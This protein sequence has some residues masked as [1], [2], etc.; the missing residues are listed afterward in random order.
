M[1]HHN[2]NTEHSAAYEE[3]LRQ[4]EE[5]R[6]QLH[7]T[8]LRMCE[9]EIEKVEVTRKY[10]YFER[11][12]DYWEDQARQIDG[13]LHTV[14][15]SKF[16]KMREKLLSPIARFRGGNDAPVVEEEP[17]R[18]FPTPDTLSELPA[19]DAWEQALMER[20]RIAVQAHVFYPD[21]IKDITAL[22]ANL[23][24]P[25]DLYITTTEKHKAVYIEEYL[26]K[27]NTAANYTVEI[28]ENRGRDVIPFLTQLQPVVSKYDYFCH[29]HTKRSLLYDIGNRWRRYLYENL[30][31]NTQ[32]I[33]QIFREFEGTP[34]V[35]LIFPEFPEYIKPYVNWAGNKSYAED[36]MVKMGFDPALL[37]DEI[38][39]PA[40]TMFWARTA[41][42]SNFFKLDLT[43]LNVP[44][45]IGQT[46]G[47]VMHAVERLWCY[48]A[49]AN[50]Y[51]YRQ[52]RNISQDNDNE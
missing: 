11:Q 13:M 21:L 32:Q 17:V 48:V 20:P 5:T 18:D 16:W 9:I 4:L 38:I 33:R 35:G 3:L 15:N 22:L 23:P 30:L 34:N 1:E 41:A 44:D 37:P 27:H 47:T 6:K 51:T 26:S 24:Y 50:G 31:G 39:F 8:E 2:T 29:I 40:G 19:S 49:Q 52:S 43:A 46:D 25:Y 28:V 7:K 14:I 10:L 42:V 36:L 45:E 12:A